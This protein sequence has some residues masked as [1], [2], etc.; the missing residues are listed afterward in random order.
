[1]VSCSGTQQ[2]SLYRCLLIIDSILLGICHPL[3]TSRLMVHSNAI[4][5]QRKIILLNLYLLEHP[6]SSKT[7]A[8]S[9]AP[10]SCPYILI[11]MTHR[12]ITTTT[13]STSSQVPTAKS[14]MMQ[15]CKTAIKQTNQHLNKMT[16]TMASCPSLCGFAIIK[17]LC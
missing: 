7:K 17:R 3:S 5:S 13:P 15:L 1:M 8:S 12:R 10:Q 11:P 2:P 14:P 6:C 16:P 4:P 9:P